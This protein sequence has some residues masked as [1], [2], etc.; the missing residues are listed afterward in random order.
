MDILTWASSL[1]D[2]TSG[3]VTVEVSIPSNDIKTIVGDMNAKVGQEEIYKGTIWLNSL[4]TGCNDD[5]RC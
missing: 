2:R 4:H 1:H 3:A 5:G